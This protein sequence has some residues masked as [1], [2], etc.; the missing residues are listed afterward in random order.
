MSYT[1]INN[2]LSFLKQIPPKI[3]AI[4]YGTE[5]KNVKDLISIFIACLQFHLKD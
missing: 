3:E 2:I 1:R 5:S 4:C